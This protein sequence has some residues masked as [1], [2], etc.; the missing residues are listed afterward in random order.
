[1]RTVDRVL[2]SSMFAM[3]LSFM[4][5]QTAR[6]CETGEIF[7]SLG[8][9]SVRPF[10]LVHVLVPLAF[11][12]KYSDFFLTIVQ[13][14]VKLAV[15]ALYRFSLGLW[16]GLHSRSRRRRRFDTRGKIFVVG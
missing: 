14:T 7:A 8:R 10:M 16:N 15:G 12:R 2:G 11:A 13:G 5:K 4:P 6:V 1:M 3:N 9:A